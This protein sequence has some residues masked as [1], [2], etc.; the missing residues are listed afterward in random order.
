MLQA[1]NI[2]AVAALLIGFAFIG[3][4]VFLR[5]RYRVNAAA[6]GDVPGFVLSPL[7]VTFGSAALSWIFR[8]ASSVVGTTANAG[9]SIIVALIN[10]A[11]RLLEQI[12]K[13]PLWAFLSG[14]VLAGVVCLLY[15]YA[16]A[17]GSYAGALRDARTAAFAAT[18]AAE[19]A[20]VDAIR[21]ANNRADQ[22]IAS[23]QADFEKKCKATPAKTGKR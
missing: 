2:A 22:A 5:L 18:K 7:A 8:S 13:S 19:T 14:A 16:W 23:I 15:G 9:A 6:S 12:G 21:T 17:A 3:C 4:E 1:S 11:P 10:V 20:K